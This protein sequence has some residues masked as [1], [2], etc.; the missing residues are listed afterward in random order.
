M[1]QPASYAAPHVTADARGEA[2]SALCG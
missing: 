2:R 1:T